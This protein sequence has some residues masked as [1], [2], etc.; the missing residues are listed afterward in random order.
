[1]KLHSRIHI[2]A[3]AKNFLR[4]R[5]ES[6]PLR[7]FAQYAA[8]GEIFGAGSGRG[9]AAPRNYRPQLRGQVKKHGQTMRMGKS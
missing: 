2:A 7:F 8:N 9:V 4:V 3:Y 1:M 5:W 6:A